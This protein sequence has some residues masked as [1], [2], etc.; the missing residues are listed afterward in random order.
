MSGFGGLKFWQSSN[1]CKR[2]GLVLRDDLSAEDRRD[3]L[4]KKSAL[5][6]K[7]DS[8]S[9]LCASCRL[10]HN[11]SQ[12][13]NAPA[14]DQSSRKASR[15][16]IADENYIVISSMISKTLSKGKSYLFWGFIGVFTLFKMTGV[17]SLFDS[18][19]DEIA[20]IPKIVTTSEEPAE[21]ATREL[22]GDKAVP[23][24]SP[25]KWITPYDYPT[26]ALREEREGVVDF[27][28]TV[29]KE[30]TVS[31]CNILDS[32]GHEDLDKATCDLLMQRAIF[33]KGLNSQG[34]SIE[35]IYRNSIRWQIPE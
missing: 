17:T 26:V 1:E 6:T 5:A 10:I 34:I 29:S 24:N 22:I 4:F 13:E 27:T 14:T 16:N 12:F 35:S 9:L 18:S 23:F 8:G 11:D 2:C 3:D 15:D 25:A 28:L 7:D 33:Y 30:G 21:T 20:D 19:S 32:S 31:S